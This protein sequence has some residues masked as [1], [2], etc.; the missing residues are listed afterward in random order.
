VSYLICEILKVISNKRFIG[1]F[2]LL[3]KCFDC[4]NHNILLQELEFCGI[5]DKAY[6]LI[7]SYLEGRQQRVVFKDKFLNNNNC[8]NWGI[9]KHGI[10]Q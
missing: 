3:R 1:G 8:S 2:F 7:K 5:T 9:I 10:L 4:V 6:T